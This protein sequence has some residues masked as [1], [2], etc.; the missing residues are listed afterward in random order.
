MLFVLVAQAD[1]AFSCLSLPFAAFSC[2][3]AC[4][5]GIAAGGTNCGLTVVRRWAA[6]AT[7]TYL[8]RCFFVFTSF[9]GLPRCRASSHSS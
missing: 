1:A 5:R 3:A 6:V 4:G 2:A 8:V 9:F 7:R